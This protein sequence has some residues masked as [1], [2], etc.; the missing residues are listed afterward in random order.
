MHS[1]DFWVLGYG[2]GKF[3]NTTDNLGVWLFHCHIEFHLFMGMG[4]VFEAR[5]EQVGMLPTSI[6]VCGKIKDK[7][8]P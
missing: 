3:N 6:M 7:I 1:H 2:Q 5:V 4:V 8:K